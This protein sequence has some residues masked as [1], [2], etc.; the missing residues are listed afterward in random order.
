M[1][2]ETRSAPVDEGAPEA[3]EDFVGDYIAYLLAAASHEVSA[4]FHRRVRE[5]GLRVPEW[6]ILCCLESRDGQAVTELA[7][8]TLFAQPTLTKILNAM[9]ENGLVERRSDP[10]DRRLVRMHITAAGSRIVTPLMAEAKRHEAEVT[11]H[12][13]A[14]ELALLKHFL[15]DLAGLLPPEA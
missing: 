9:A 6:R 13:S 1:T 7:R 11:R 5:A 8:T 14:R 12:F 10:G 15:K 2:E 4:S 3:A